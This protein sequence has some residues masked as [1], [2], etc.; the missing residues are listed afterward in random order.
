M[1]LIKRTGILLIFTM[2][3]ATG[4]ATTNGGDVF[5]DTGITTRVKTAIFNEPGLKVM[6]IKVSTEN[7]V[8]TL[9]GTVKTPGE[10][11]R[12]VAVAKQVEGVKSVRNE[13]H[14]QK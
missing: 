11:M 9:S 7:Q 3:L 2:L 6:D 12:A 5:G 14:V 4:C 10:R 13:I 8:V 1:N